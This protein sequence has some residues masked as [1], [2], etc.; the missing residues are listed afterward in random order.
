MSRLDSEGVEPQATGTALAAP[1]EQPAAGL[2][3]LIERVAGAV[4]TVDDLAKFMSLKRE[5]EG[6]A[7]RRAFDHDFAE[8][9]GELGQVVAN[10]FDQQKRRAYADINALLAVVG[11][12]CAA[13]GFALSFDT[14]PPVTPATVRVVVKL[15]RNGIERTSS[16]DMPLDGQGMRG[17]ANMSAAQGYV[18]TTT[19]GRK[20]ALTLLFN[21]TVSSGQQRPAERLAPQRQDDVALAKL[22]AAAR[23]AR[24][25]PSDASILKLEAFLRQ[26]DARP[27]AVIDSDGALE[28]EDVKRFV[29]RRNGART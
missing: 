2:P 11:P 26:I 1:T 21:L 17:N 27:E 14:Q 20:A 29:E 10:A 15:V 5:V 16:V 12:A 4:A 18:S 7:E 9:Q 24:K 25:P 13:R 22:R 28:V 19:Y 3:A 8:L 6:E 23:K